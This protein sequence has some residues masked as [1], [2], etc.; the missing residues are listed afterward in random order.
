MH[1]SFYV[2]RKNN[3]N[4]CEYVKVEH[5]DVP[6]PIGKEFF[7]ISKNRGL[8]NSHPVYNSYL[9]WTPM[10]FSKKFDQRSMKQCQKNYCFKELTIE[11]QCRNELVA[12]SIN[13]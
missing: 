5:F 13:T 8:R 9:L 1:E 2:A 11:I 6:K 7:F 10:V 4:T 12:S 3:I